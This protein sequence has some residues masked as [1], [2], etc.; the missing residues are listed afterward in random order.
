MQIL[1]QNNIVIFYG[2]IEKGVYDSVDP[3]RELYQ[4]TNDN[5]VFY[6]VTENFTTF[7]VDSV[8]DDFEQNKYLYIE[9]KGFERNENWVDPNAPTSEEKLRSDVDYLAMMTGI[10]LGGTE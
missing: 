3:D 1:T 9:G 6:A 2:E 4:I 5:G 10:D 8:P 7:E